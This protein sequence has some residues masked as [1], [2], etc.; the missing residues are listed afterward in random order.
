MNNTE[1][2]LASKEYV[3]IGKLRT[4]KKNTTMVKKKKDGGWG[5]ETLRRVE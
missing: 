3:I 1:Q 2:T 5:T 4:R